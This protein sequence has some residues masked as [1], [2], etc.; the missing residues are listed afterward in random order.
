MQN[1]DDEYLLAIKLLTSFHFNMPSNVHVEILCLNVCKYA[2]IRTYF[3]VLVYWFVVCALGA[4]NVSAMMLHVPGYLMYLSSWWW[5]HGCMDKL[6]R[7]STGV[8]RLVVCDIF[9]PHFSFQG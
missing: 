6:Q 4:Y 9:I 5:V 3:F 8:M 7:I 1:C 2:H